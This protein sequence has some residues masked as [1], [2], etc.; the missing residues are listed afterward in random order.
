MLDQIIFGEKLRNHRKKL[1]MTQEEVAEKVGVSPQAISKWEAGDCLP[2]CFNLK[3]ISDVYKISAD[4]LLETESNGDLSTVAGKIEQLAT[5]FTWSPANY[6][7][8]NTN[9]R[10]ELG[11]DLW[12]MWKGVYFAEV[13]DKTLQ[14]ESKKQGNL[15]IIGSF[16]TKI[17]DDNGVAC[18]IK[19]SLI[20]QLTTYDQSTIE[21]IQALCSE[22]G[23]RLIFAMRCDVP[24]SKQKIIEETNID[25]SRL[26]ELL[27][28]F[29]ENRI[30]EFVADNRS[31]D[32]GYLICGHCGIVAYMVLSAMYILNKKN[33]TVSQ[34]L[35]G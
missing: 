32:R 2:D 20:D 1:G 11:E 9:L 33:Y 30:I 16:G 25:V 18:V 15:R 26:N 12:E 34:F 28:L 5:E 13:G 14:E 23:Q 27:L 35:V 21:V 17:W 4:V 29:T 8:Y 10:Q 31:E 19:S 6:D 24:T 3:A 7:R 22:E